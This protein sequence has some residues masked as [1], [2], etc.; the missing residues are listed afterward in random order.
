[1][2]RH[3]GY[4]APARDTHL[5]KAKVAIVKARDYD[6]A[7]IYAGVEKGIE[8]IGGLEKIVKPRSSVFVKTFQEGNCDRP[9]LPVPFGNPVRA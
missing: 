2:E 6:R 1:M 5:N 7:Q 9:E 3:E 4:S 8:L